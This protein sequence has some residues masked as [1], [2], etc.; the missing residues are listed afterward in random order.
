MGIIEVG[1]NIYTNGN[2]ISLPGLNMTENNSVYREI[3]KTYIMQ[4]ITDYSSC[5]NTV[6]KIN[7]IDAYCK[8]EPL[9]KLTVI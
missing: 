4:S 7:V 9:P 8:S 6:K 3:C 2:G 1:I 5:I